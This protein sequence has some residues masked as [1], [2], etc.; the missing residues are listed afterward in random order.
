MVLVEEIEDDEPATNVPAAKVRTSGPAVEET[1]P[2][3]GKREPALK[4]G[5]LSG[6]GAQE[7]LYGPEGSPEGAVAP[8]THKAHAEHK[9][10]DDMNKG[11]NRGAEDNNG[12]ARP[13]W[14]T[15]EWPKDCQYNSPGCSLGEFESSGHATEMHREMV[16]RG[17]RW[18]EAMSGTAKAMRMSFM[19]LTDE[20]LEV[21]IERLRDNAAV[22]E[23]DLSHNKIKDRGVQLLVA[24]LSKGA[25]P[26]LRELRIYSN[27]FGDLGRT[28]LAQGLRIL[29]KGIE[30]QHEQPSWARP[31]PEPAAPTQPSALAPDGDAMD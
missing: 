19:Q 25:A 3:A 14:Y 7:R 12:F 26:S 13:P 23:L 1:S 8:E 20:D 9:M 2:G 11:M 5:F 21:V 16:R 18:D 28:M 24:A 29:R 4:R 30:I 22:E 31:A 10:N 6:D 27:E 15:A 17:E